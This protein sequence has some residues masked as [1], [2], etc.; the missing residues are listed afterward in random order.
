MLP[1]ATTLEEIEALLPWNV[2]R[3]ATQSV[4]A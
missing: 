2:A 4:A 1:Q 3:Q